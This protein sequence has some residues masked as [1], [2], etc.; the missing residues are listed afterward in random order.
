MKS[1]PRRAR[2]RAREDH[3]RTRTARTDR[4]VPGISGYDIMK[5]SSCRWR[6]L[7]RATGADL[8]TLERSRAGLIAKRDVIQTDRPNKRL[9]PSRQLPADA[10]RLA[11][12]S[13]RAIELK[14][15]PLLRCRFSAT[16]APTAR[17]RSSRKSGAMGNDLRVYRE[18]ERDYFPQSAALKC[19][20]EFRWFTLKRG[21]MW[22]EENIRWCDFAIDE[23][24]RNRKLFPAFTP[25]ARLPPAQSSR[26]TPAARQFE[27]RLTA[28]L[29]TSTRSVQ[30]DLIFCPASGGNAHAAEHFGGV[31]AEAR[32][33]A[34]VREVRRLSI[35]RGRCP[36]NANRDPAPEPIV[37]KLLRAAKCRQRDCLPAAES[38]TTRAR[39]IARA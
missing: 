6:I 11:R 32:G 18:L 20:C 27:V 26:A 22:M 10:G 8:P 39:P 16:S 38:A 33:A 37:A 35:V 34:R 23:I 7:A 14:H 3:A 28:A 19:K 25:R 1:A 13:F 15:P 9:S 31:L 12:E 5:M 4:R 17:A 24:E 30:Q 36:D 21:I 29:V 2:A